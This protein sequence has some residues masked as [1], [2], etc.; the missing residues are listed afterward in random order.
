MYHN[1]DM[2]RASEY[3]PWAS[4]D[5]RMCSI[6]IKVRLCHSTCP[7]CPVSLPSDSTL[8]SSDLYLLCMTHRW[9]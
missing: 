4:R 7:Q 2:Y 5:V 6:E 3:F 9:M 1:Y 8:A